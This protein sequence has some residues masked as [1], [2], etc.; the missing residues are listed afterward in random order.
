MPYEAC[1]HCV[2]GNRI[3]WDSR[4]N[5]ADEFWIKEN[6]VVYTRVKVRPAGVRPFSVK[7]P[8]LTPLMVREVERNLLLWTRASRVMTHRRTT[9]P[10]RLLTRLVGSGYEVIATRHVLTI[11]FGRVNPW[12]IGVS[13]ISHP[14]GKLRLPCIVRFKFKQADPD[15]ENES[16][17]EQSYSEIDSDCDSE[18]ECESDSDCEAASGNDVRRAKRIL[19]SV[20]NYRAIETFQRAY[21]VGASS[22]DT[23]RL[24]TRAGWHATDR[25]TWINLNNLPEKVVLPPLALR[26]QGGTAARVGGLHVAPM[27]VQRAV[28][29]FE[30]SVDDG[31]RVRVAPRVVDR[32]RRPPARSVTGTCGRGDSGRCGPE[33][34]HVRELGHHG[35]RISRRDGDGAHGHG[36]HHRH[37]A[38]LRVGR[39]IQ[40][41]PRRRVG[42][43]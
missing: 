32:I 11:V 3:V 30:S 6:S 2:D 14:R 38:R 36:L 37:A 23:P 26:L 1:L 21:A 40:I 39:W 19:G 33:V 16:D 18:S 28:A 5:G 41:K 42:L 34:I 8:M 12:L 20:Q 27:A 29:R 4:G 7:A 15:S 22:E 35:V 13:P 43:C 24:G 9:R 10:M 17:T 31:R 25:Q